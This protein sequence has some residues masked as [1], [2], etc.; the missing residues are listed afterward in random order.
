MLAFGGENTEV[1]CWDPRARKS[2]GNIDV[3]ASISSM[4]EE[5]SISDV[6]PEISC[7]KFDKDG[8]TMGVGTSTGQCLIYDLRMSKP[9]IVKDHQ[10]GY[11]VHNIAYIEKEIIST[12]KKILKIW[13]KQSGKV[14][15]NIETP[16]FINDVCLVPR[17][18]L[19]IFACEQSRLLSYFLP[20]LGPAPSWCSF[21]DN[22]TEEL[23]ETKQSLYESYKFV[24]KEELE[25]L[26]LTKLI[27]T[28]HLKAYMHGY[29]MDFK[30]YSK[31]R[32]IAEPFEYE[33][34][35]QE[36]IQAK[37]AQQAASR[38]SVRKRAPKVNA[39]TAARILISQEEKKGQ[40][41]L[42]EDP[43]F[44]DMFINKDFEVDETDDKFKFYHTNEKVNTYISPLKR[45]FSN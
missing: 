24:T 37:L 35:K 42:L 18:G 43:R 32:A 12:D 40:S 45:N 41:N 44:K 13:D 21:L 31:L 23:E 7:I 19:F 36:K 5:L 17:S 14:Q 16:S 39:K 27:G 26:G 9:L 29:F 1:E 2:V 6:S 3:E 34:Y 22:L 8:I 38:I 33:K 20:K 25:S 10:Y 15:V 4:L 28:E 11:P 30:Y